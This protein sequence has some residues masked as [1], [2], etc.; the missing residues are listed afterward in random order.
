MLHGQP[1]SGGDWAGVAADLRGRALDVLAPDRP[2]YGAS[3]LPA[4]GFAHNARAM[5]ELLDGPAIVAGHSW[6]AGV[7]VAMAR[8]QPDG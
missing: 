8:L 1:G 7:A 2:G 3:G 5:A 6:G 4:G